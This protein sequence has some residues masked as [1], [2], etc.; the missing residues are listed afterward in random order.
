MDTQRDVSRKMYLFYSSHIL[1]R[2]FTAEQPRGPTQ[3][4]LP[5][6]NYIWHGTFRNLSKTTAKISG[7]YFYFMMIYGCHI[8]T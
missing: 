8:Q 1:T 6:L 2:H 3:I 5:D 4:P 7:F